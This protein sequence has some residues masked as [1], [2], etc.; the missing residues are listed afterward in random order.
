VRD[1]NAGI[2]REGGGVRAER[3]GTG[4]EASKVKRFFLSP[5]HSF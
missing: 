3:R 2:V 5:L 4:A 1:G